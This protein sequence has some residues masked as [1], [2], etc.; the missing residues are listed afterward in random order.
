MENKH[1]MYPQTRIRRTRSG[2]KRIT[3]KTRRKVGKAN[4]RN[5][6]KII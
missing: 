3:R 5:R 1:S 2:I 4:K 6:Y